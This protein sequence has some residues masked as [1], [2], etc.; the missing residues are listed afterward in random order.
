MVEPVTTHGPGPA[1]PAEPRR[2][3]RPTW[4]LITILIAVALGALIPI[5][6]MKTGMPAQEARPGI[7]REVAPTSGLHPV[8][9]PVAGA[10]SGPTAVDDYNYV[11][12][13]IPVRRGEMIAY[14]DRQALYVVDTTPVEMR[15]TDMIIE[16]LANEESRAPKYN[17]YVPAATAPRRDVSAAFYYLKM[18]ENKYLTVTLQPMKP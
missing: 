5:L 1:N 13:T 14:L 9:E 18:G 10:T 17:L 6:W 4:V 16:G 15:D 7:D 3:R 12:L 8:D 2:P 11:D